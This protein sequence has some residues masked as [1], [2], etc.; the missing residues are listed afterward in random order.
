MVI[1]VFENYKNRKK[2]TKE[3]SEEAAKDFL[4]KKGHLIDRNKEVLVEKTKEGKP[5]LKDFS[6]FLSISHT[7][8]LC[9]IALSKSPIGIDVEKVKSIDWM[10]ISNR[11]FNKE[12]S[13]YLM[14]ECSPNTFFRMWT[15]KEAYAKL[16]GIPLLRIIGEDVAADYKSRENKKLYIQRCQIGEGYICTACKGGEK[17]EAEY[18]WK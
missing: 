14:D 4:I 2:S 6:V 8:N 11:F 15:E 1:Y 7:E 12:E 3:L 16:L 9:L 5:Y 13:N 18:E 10:K 17:I